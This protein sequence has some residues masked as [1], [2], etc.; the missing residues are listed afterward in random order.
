PATEIVHS[1][2]PGGADIFRNIEQAYLS[3]GTKSGWQFDFG[4]FVTQHGAEVIETKDNWNYSR[5]LLF[6][7]A[8]PYYHFGVRATYPVNDQF[9]F[10]AFL[11][12]GWNN[13]VDNN[14]GKTIG[15][16]ALWKPTKKLTIVQNYMG[17]PE[18]FNNNGDW[19]HLSDTLV[20]YNATDKFSLMGNYDYGSDRVNGDR[21]HWQGVAVYARGQLNDWFAVSP[22]FE[23]Y[24]DADGFTTGLKQEVKDFTFTTEQKIHKG[25]IS[26]FEYRRDFSDEPFF[27]KRGDQLVKAQSTFTFGIIYAFSSKSE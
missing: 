15:L 7:L 2:E 6:A 5:S 14:S 8:I 3:I 12:N 10:T 19:R 17:G 11:V 21:I 23:W 24:D 26:R 16:Q 18:Q 4:K 22:R 20:T 9:T 25:V 1:L 13:V 27:L